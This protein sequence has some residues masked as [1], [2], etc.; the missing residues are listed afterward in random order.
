M[1][2]PHYHFIG[3]GGIGISAVARYYKNLGYTISGSNDSDSDLIHD[4]R[5]E[6]IDIIIGHQAGNIPTKTDKIIYTK[7]AL[8]TANTFE[9]WYRNHV[10]LTA[11]VERNIPLISYPDALAEIVN[12][13]K[14]IAITGTHGKSTTTA[15]AGIM[16]AGSNVG[17][18]MIVGTQ[19][20]GLGNSNLHFEPSEYF[21]IEACEYKRSFLKYFPYI[22]VITNIELDHLDYYH[23]LEDYISAFQSLINQTT[24]YVIYDMDDINAQKLDFSQ[25]SAKPI[26]V[27]HNG[28]YDENNIFT[29]FQKLNLQVPGDH[30]EFDAK[31]AFVVGKI[32]WLE[33]GYIVDKLNSYTGAWRRSEIIRTTAH[34]NLLMSDYGHHPTEIRLTLEA[35]K[36]KYP[37][38]HLFVPFQP[39]Q[40]SR[41]I[42]LLDGFKTCFDSADSLVISDIYFSRD[43]QEDVA[44]MTTERFVGELRQ[45]YPHT[46]NGN[47]LDHTLE[48]IRKY[49]QEHPN[50]AVIVLLWAGTID[51]LRGEIK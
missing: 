19:V 22:T 31:L 1:T 28:W 49:D 23:D 9:E 20:P 51:D 35:I 37:D 8:Q 25:T 4:L 3:I 41:T 10:E 50:S 32:V 44:Y 39:H 16:L 45:N 7:A 46:I 30:I 47:G 42:E 13:K 24:W 40:Y 38:K 34:G 29:R 43:K 48:I 15:M 36:N 11:W 12:A 18:S 2:Q 26:R 33:D 14:C 17:G 6:G 5:T 27:N 21:V